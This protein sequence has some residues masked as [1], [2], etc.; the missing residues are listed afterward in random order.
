MLRNTVIFHLGVTLMAGFVLCG[1]LLGCS[2]GEQKK[3]TDL[4]KQEKTLPGYEFSGLDK[5]G[6]ACTT[7]PQKFVSTAEM[8]KGLKDSA[9]NNDCALDKRKAKFMIDCDTA[10]NYG[11]KTCKVDLYDVATDKS[12]LSKE[13]CVGRR[14]DN[15]NQ[16]VGRVV[17]TVGDIQLSVILSLSA[18]SKQSPS[19]INLKKR[20]AATGFVEENSMS[21]SKF[22]DKFGTEA[23]IKNST[24]KLY[25]NCNNVWNCP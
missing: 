25:I 9:A 7:G 5:A 14:A 11:A 16:I 17:E 4:E 13:I 24:T 15:G 23:D 2:N 10:A 22:D 8:C 6:Q 21:L 20:V 19:G 3:K 12:L 18:R 1:P